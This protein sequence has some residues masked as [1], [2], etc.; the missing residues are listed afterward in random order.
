MEKKNKLVNKVKRLIRKAGLPRWLHHYGPK[1]YEFWH[2]A[3]ALVI[4]QECRLGYRRVSNLLDM[5]GFKVPTYS[6]LAKMAKRL[7]ISI[8]QKLLSATIGNK[9]YLVAID[10]TGMSRPL[11]SPYYYR[12][13]DKPYPID[14]PLKL[15]ISI[16]TRTKKVLSLRLRAK[17]AHDVKDAKYL[18][19]R[20]QFKPYKVVADKGYDAN[21]LHRYCLRRGIKTCI[22]T[23]DYGKTQYRKTLRK[24]LAKEIKQKTYGRREM[25]EST[26]KSIKCKFGSSV[27][28]IK[29][30]AQRAEVYC[31]AIAHNIISLFIGYFQRSRRVKK[32]LTSYLR[33]FW[34][35]QQ[36]L[37]Q[38][39]PFRFHSINNH[40]PF[41][42]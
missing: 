6:A 36:F 38:L 33:L 37:Y 23:R 9:P 11:P 21:W 15:S 7:P 40:K 18:I 4:K 2:H 32:L 14:I 34:L 42:K 8:W 30:S 39:Q 12:R 27:S 5:L 26:F 3:L 19:K 41:L 17:R 10:G 25:V 29:I 28:C 31:R 35:F 20:F 13:I 22:P 1:K 16:D 24:R